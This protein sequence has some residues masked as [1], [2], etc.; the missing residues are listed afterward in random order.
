MSWHIER[1]FTG[2]DG[3]AVVD[4]DA[5]QLVVCCPDADTAIDTINVLL[6][7][8]E[9]D[10]AEDATEAPDPV[11]MMAGKMWGNMLDPRSAKHLDK[12]L[13]N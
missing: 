11:D 1:D 4:D 3:Y 9:I 13:R 5:K 2:C 8:D 10:D 6:T 12:R 7:A